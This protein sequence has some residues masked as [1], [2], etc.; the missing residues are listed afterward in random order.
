[1]SLDDDRLSLAE[2][3][4]IL[5]TSRLIRLDTTGRS[6]SSSTRARQNLEVN[7]MDVNR[8]RPALRRV[9]QLPQLD[10]AKGHVGQQ[11]VLDVGEG[12]AV[13]AP[14]ASG[15]GEAERVVDG[16]RGAGGEGHVAE[17]GGDDGGVGRGEGALGDVEAHD[18]VGVVVVDL[19][20]E[21][22]DRGL[23]AELDG[24]AL[25]VGE[26]EDDLVALSNGEDLSNVSVCI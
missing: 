8:M 14:L 1:M 22:A 15:A 21:A 2:V 23:V 24:L 17:G 7:K 12:D 6:T 19:D 5:E 3:D 11:T 25:E 20:A 10:G 16:G 26:V 18:L 9:R 4:D 13:D